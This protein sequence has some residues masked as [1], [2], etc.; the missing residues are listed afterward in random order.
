[1]DNPVL[2]EKIIKKHSLYLTLL[3][4]LLANSNNI[5]M[6]DNINAW[7]KSNYW[8][9][10]AMIIVVPWIIIVGDVV[11]LVYAVVTAVGDTGLALGGGGQGGY[12]SSVEVA[13]LSILFITINV[14]F[15]I[16]SRDI[17]K[18]EITKHKSSCVYNYTLLDRFIMIA[19]SCG[20]MYCFI[21]LIHLFILTQ[22]YTEK[23]LTY[24]KGMFLLTIVYYLYIIIKKRINKAKSQKECD[25]IP[26]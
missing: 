13:I 8:L 4:T 3:I 22:R 25:L 24:L 20:I 10:T 2:D 23:G 14:L 16:S 26:N 9:V 5:L 12:P 15:G 21:Y 11:A 19:L 18:N 7:D 17:N 1:M 6:L